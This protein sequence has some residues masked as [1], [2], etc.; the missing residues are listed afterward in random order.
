MLRVPTEGKVGFWAERIGI[1]VEHSVGDD[2]VGEGVG[3]GCLL[4]SLE[5]MRLKDRRPSTGLT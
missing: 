2:G 5:R 1:R 3:G 4:L